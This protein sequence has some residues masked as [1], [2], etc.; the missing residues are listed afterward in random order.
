MVATERYVD[1]SCI[2][3][4]CRGNQLGACSFY[5]LVGVV[6]FAFLKAGYFRGSHLMVF[7]AE[8]GSRITEHRYSTEVET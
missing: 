2:T 4:F 3:S 8:T 7:T 6:T 1:I 5:T